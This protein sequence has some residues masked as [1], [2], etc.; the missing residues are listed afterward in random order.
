MNFNLNAAKALLGAAVVAGAVT[1]ISQPA[2]AI[3]VNTSAGPTSSFSGV[4]TVGF[5]NVNVVVPSGSS[6]SSVS[7]T[8]YTENGITF[9][10]GGIAKGSVGS[11]FAS[12]PGSN[13]YLTLGGTNEPSPVTIA[14]GGLKGYFGLF[15]GSLDTYNTIEFINTIA[16]TSQAFTGGMVAALTGTPSTGDQKVGVYY[17]FFGDNNSDLFNQVKLSS[18]QAAFEVDNIA[19]RTAIPT[20]A[21]LPGLI[22]MGVAAWRKRKGESVEQ[23]EA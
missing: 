7:A 13:N 22:G 5:E 14:L 10:H 8:G 20:P 19:T 2:S 12:P 23:S 17:N 6:G 3:S 15:V 18:S 21:L 4:T 11:Q 1:A 9:T 16:G